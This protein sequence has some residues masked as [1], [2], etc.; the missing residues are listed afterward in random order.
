MQRSMPYKARSKSV[1]LAMLV[2][3]G[4]FVVILA[5]LPGAAGAEGSRDLYPAGK[6]G[7]RANIEW[8]NSFYG[9]FLRR[10]SL[11][12]VY[13]EAGEVLLLGSSAVGVQ[14]GD[15]RVYDPNQVTGPVG[16]EIIPDTPN[17]SCEAQRTATGNPNQGQ[18]TSRAMELAGPDTI[19]DPVTATPGNAIS[20]GYIPC[21]YTASTSG[22]YH[23]V[24]LGPAGDNSDLEIAAT[25]EIDLASPDNFNEQQG[26]SIAVWDVTV[27]TDLTSTVDITGRLFVDYLTRFTGDWPRPAFSTYFISTDGGYIYR[28]D[29]RGIDANG[30][31]VYAND[32]GFRNSDGTTLYHDVVADPS[33]PIQE[34]NQLN[35]LQ[36]GVELALPTHLIFFNPPSDEARQAN[37]FL[38]EPLVPRIVSL[39]F[40]GRLADNDTFVGGGGVFTFT[41]NI[42]GSYELVISRDGVDFSP[43]LP[44]NRVLR[45]THQAG[46]DVII[47]D[48]LDNAGSPFPV[49]QN[50][51]ARFTDRGGEYHFPMLD[52]E[53]SL[54]GGP[55]LELLNPPGGQ[56]P[57]FEGQ[58]PNC[59]IAFY[60]DRGY[61]TAN[62]TDV[63]TPGQ[64][65]PNGV[66]PNP[67]NSN[68]LTG[69]DTT[70]TQRRFGD[71][72]ANGFGDAKGLDLWTFFPSEVQLVTID[73][74]PLNVAIEKT[75]NGITTYPGGVIPY[76]LFYTN[77]EAID[78]IGTVI[79]EVV[80]L[81]T[82]FN[83]TASQPTQWSCVDGSLAGT[84]CTT[85]IGFLASGAGGTA[86]FAVTVLDNVP[87]SVTQIDNIAIIGEDGS[88]GPEPKIDN[89][90]TEE[91]PLQQSP[92]TSTPTTTAT[93]TATKT[94]PPTM[95]MT[96]T[97]SRTPEI[98]ETPVPVPSTRP[99]DDN[100]DDNGNNDDDDDQ[101]DDDDGSSTRPTPSTPS[102]GQ[103]TTTGEGTPPSTT[104]S[105]VTP[106]PTLPVLFLPETG[107]REAGVNYFAP[108]YTPQGYKLNFFETPE[109]SHNKTYLERLL[110]M[111][112]FYKALCTK[113]IPKIQQ[114]EKP[115]L[116]VKV[117]IICRIYLLEM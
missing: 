12:Q 107:Q 38:L 6:A 100:D 26:T 57:S 86:N 59:N 74:L 37:N 22:I 82:T 18:I 88:R 54:E 76:T 48:G 63:G 20:D 43:D 39:E 69:F 84:T 79:T 45:G 83:A 96:P 14:Q 77:T 31:V 50:Y 3:L 65:L 15:I 55:T 92:P 98:T 85:S 16:D 51:Q 28:T 52:I 64:V 71:G 46:A 66:P 24:F 75:D 53:S 108:T 33:I 25:G 36:G 112:P 68:P 67:P 44:T 91:T 101:N 2:C 90:D 60:D 110:A 4:S 58:P 49:G 23:V 1:W 87:N 70:T 117:K 99:T 80:P 32:I 61:T 62:G 95:T 9:N 11:F 19:V 21:F 56:C 29:M 13:A 116:F 97:S 40:Q 106:T 35:L 42:D 114:S 30:F 109:D 94:N 10:R 103:T 78:A 105:Q 113:L 72:T 115:E 89:Q 104:P 34:Q 5:M 47:W 17:F 102:S 8:R 7:N 93:A 81:H 41:S 73:I 111:M 27:R